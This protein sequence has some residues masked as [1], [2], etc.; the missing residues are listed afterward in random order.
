MVDRGP[1]AARH[2]LAVETLRVKYP[3]QVEQLHQ[4]ELSSN[5]NLKCVYCSSPTLDKPLTDS[6]GKSLPITQGGGF[7]RAKENMT[8][9]T[10]ERALEH[11]KFYDRQGTQGELAL[12]GIGEALIHPDFPQLCKLARAA[13]PH[14][15]I[16]LS[17][18]GLILANR[19]TDAARELSDRLLDSLEENRVAVYVSLHR[20]ERAKLAID[21]LRKRGLLAATN[22]AFATESFDW[23]GGLDWEV[24]IPEG[25]VTCEFLRS[26]WCVV[27]ADGRV[28]ACC[29]DSEGG[30]VSGHVDDPLGSLHIAPWEGVKQGCS[31]CHMSPPE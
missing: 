16:T 7:G 18:N 26:G 1:G 14:N 10:F 3:R 6:A 23:A 9:A 29:L 22:Q 2:P 31:G 21:L 25:S 27:L 17:T 19:K 11:A 24:S 5:C 8:L 30:G 28:T 20:P 4:L 12:T 15:L 13:L